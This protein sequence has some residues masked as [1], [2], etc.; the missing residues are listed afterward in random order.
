MLIDG[1]LSLAKESGEV[2]CF[3]SMYFE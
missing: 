1:C 3:I 2:G